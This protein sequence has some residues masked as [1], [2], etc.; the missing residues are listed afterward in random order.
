M[1]KVLMTCLLL[2]AQTYS[3]PPSVMLGIYQVEGGR[4]GQAVGPNTDGSYDIGPMQINTIWLPELSSL[5]QVNQRTAYTWLQEDPCTNA[6]V[7]A[8]ILR[9][10]WNE[11]RDWG[12]AISYYH[13]RTPHLGRAY[14]NKV[15][16]AMRDL[17]Y[18]R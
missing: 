12:T 1:T 6:G 17:G 3:V 5:W 7:A 16:H 11:T 14:K 8:W 9:R 15:V 18:L 4:V 13:S 2:A 10:H